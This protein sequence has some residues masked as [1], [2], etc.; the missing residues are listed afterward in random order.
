MHSQILEAVPSHN[1]G[2][3]KRDRILQ[4]QIIWSLL[5]LAA[6]LTYAPALV[7]IDFKE[8]ILGTQPLT[9]AGD[10]AS[11]LVAGV[12]RFLLREI[13]KAQENRAK[14]WNRNGSSA[15]GL[16]NS[17]ATNR[18]RLAHIL[19]MRDSRSTTGGFELI[20]DTRQGARVAS[21]KGFTVSE[22]RWQALDGI[23]AEGLMLTPTSG[24]IHPD[25]VAIPDADVT[26]EGLVGLTNGVAAASQYARLLAEA[27]CRVLVPTLINRK[28]GDPKVAGNNRGSALSNREFVY[29]SAFE[30]G[31]HLIGYEVQKVLAAVDRFS[32]ESGAGARIGVVGWGEGGAIALYAAALDSR[33]TTA[34]VSGYFT[35]R[36][37]IWQEPIDRNV[38]GLLEQFGDAELASMVAPRSLIIEAARGP[39]VEL[40]GAGGGAPSTLTTPDVETVKKE[41]ARARKL[42]P[43]GT[44]G[45]RF[46]FTMSGDG[47]GPE[48]A[49]GTLKTVLSELGLEDALKPAIEPALSIERALPDAARRVRSQMVEMDRFTQRVLTESAYTRQDF[50]KKLDTSSVPKY[51]ETAR[52]YRDY[53][54]E[55]VIGRFQNPL[56]PAQPR[57]RKVYDEE[58]WVGY[59]VVLDVFEDVIAYGLLLL[60]KDLKDG[61]KRPV[62]VCQHGLEGR[63]QH[64]IGKEGFQYYSAF[65]AKLAERG[66]V[67]F[68]PQNLYIFTDRFR[69]LQRKANA[70]KK[71]LFS[72][73]T[74]QHQ[75]IINWLKTQPYVDGE[76]IA[77]YGLSYGGKTAMRVPALLTD[78]CLSI[79]SADFNEWVW[80]N[81][82]TRSPYSY[83]WGGEYEIFEF[84][85]GST[86]NYAEMAALIAPRPF[87]VER[88]HFDGVAPD[89]T[90]GYEFAK[91]RFLYA[92]KLGLGDRA[93]LEWFVGPHSINGKGTYDFLHKHLAWPKP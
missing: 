42:L 85:L 65:S 46:H 34:C 24:G 72:V 82:S 93:Q 11:N 15:E 62:V 75:Q 92:A 13:E 68:A 30:L 41:F 53:F 9:L 8:N 38:F 77:F 3:S 50:M 2:R 66:F 71:T 70:I 19:G 20:V 12:D 35:S 27:G 22:V 29:R 47:K 16:E 10:V 48:L 51:E 21:G 79:C 31:R 49:M 5:A 39:E 67:V 43:A 58:K 14:F 78:Y 7:A 55:E 23:F 26:P 54:Y 45:N 61:E 6:F 37:T 60:P 86:F 84:D 83:V 81:A 32:K 17:I 52:S 44:F 1:R 40:K 74:P 25:V 73:I 57:T 28:M 36:N 76:R 64:T 91:V 59:E 80:K 87:M 4:P 56:L 33:I 63:P 88:G 90:V 18:A 89:E 69:T